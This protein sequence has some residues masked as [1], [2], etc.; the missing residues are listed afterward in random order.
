MST[1]TFMLSPTERLTGIRRERYTKPRSGRDIAYVVCDRLGQMEFIGQ[2][3]P[4]LVAAINEAVGEGQYARVSVNGLW[5]SVD[6][7]DGR[8]GPWCKGRWRVRAVSLEHACE[9]FERE[10]VAHDRAAVVAGQPSR[11]AIRA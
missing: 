7:T 2:K 5:E 6:R 3:I 1:S 4:L 11:Y 9:E 8:A 10:R